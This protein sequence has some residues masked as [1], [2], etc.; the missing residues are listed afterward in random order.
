MA[1]AST[2]MMERRGR[3]SRLAKMSLFIRDQGSERR[4]GA[5]KPLLQGISMG[6]DEAVIVLIRS[7]SA[8]KWD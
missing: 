3:C 8:G 4:Q 7:R 1:T 5:L 2:L 6:A